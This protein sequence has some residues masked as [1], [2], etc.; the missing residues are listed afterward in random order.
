MERPLQNLVE[1]AARSCER[2]AERPA[3]GTKRDGAW[4]WTSY[5][6]FSALVERCRAGL[7]GLGV[8]SGDVVA[9]VSDNRLEWAVAYY[10][11]AGLEAV[12]VPMYEAQRPSE[13]QFILEDCGA[14]LVLAGAGQPYERLLELRPELPNLAHVV[15]IGLPE[16][17][18]A[19]FEAM[20][21]A[22][23][24]SPIP[25]RDPAPTTTAGLIYTSGTTGKPKGVKLSHANVASNARTG[26]MIFPLSPD[27]RTL[28]FL[29]WAHSYGQL[30]LNWALAQGASLAL[31]DDIQQLLPNLAD[32][33]PTVLVTVPRVFNRV[34]ETVRKD[35]AE[36]PA[37]LQRL[38]EDGTRAAIRKNRGEH[39]NLLER[40]ELAL[41]D[42]LIFEKVRQRFG[43]RLKYVLCASAALSKDV[44]EFVDALGLQV[45]EGYGLTETSPMVSANTPGARRMGSVGKVIPG[46]QVAI[47]T[48]RSDVP[49]Q[50]EIV[51]YGPNVMQ[52]Y[53]NRP[54]ENEKVFTEDG[55]LRTGDLG[56]IDDDGFLYVTGRIKEQYKLAN[57]KYVMPGPLEEQL[58]LSRYIANVMLFGANRPYNVALV[59]IE[60]TAVREWASKQGFELA[61]PTGDARVEQLIHDEVKQLAR[62]FRDFEVPRR[63]VLISEDFTT[64]NGLLTPTLKLK[65]RHV[66]ARH[67]GALEALYADAAE[68][69]PLRPNAERA[70]ASK[71]RA[72]STG[73]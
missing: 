55:G 12:F 56:Y 35:M 17:H 58:K 7:Y 28:S 16:A 73:H 33:K 48:S 32:V 37:L 19:S 72:P 63:I 57:G 4:H 49:G 71:P 13:W 47:D 11:S 6:E 31:N 46:V 9:I 27:D 1:L 44:A 43:G 25:A 34:Y 10:A 66:E 51:V 18:P 39:L 29:P 67:G 54:E 30:E 22:G 21:D 68:S 3:F 69:G 45:Y 24:R 40:I 8:R 62:S 50:G 65:R 70:S 53:H 38:F 59:V 41:D 61:E 60:Q 64:E 42:K 23:A 15:G 20:L 52:G 14:Q 26:A 5:R 36:R 2:F